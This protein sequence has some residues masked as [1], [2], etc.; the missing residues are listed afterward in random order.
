MSIE[1]KII[2]VRVATLLELVKIVLVQVEIILV[3]V[4]MAEVLTS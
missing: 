2:L 4:K 1:R 3:P